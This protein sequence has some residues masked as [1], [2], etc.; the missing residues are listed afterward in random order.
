VVTIL[1]RR[2]AAL[3]ERRSGSHSGMNV[4]KTGTVEHTRYPDEVGDIW[5]GPT[6]NPR[7]NYFGQRDRGGGI[8]G[9]K[10]QERGADLQGT[11]K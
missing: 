8:G 3:R 4:T 10:N 5:V 7:H 6:N 9:E 2:P 11:T 1:S